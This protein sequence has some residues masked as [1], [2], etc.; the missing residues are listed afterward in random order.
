MENINIGVV[1]Y[2]V[3]NKLKDSYFESNLL[4]ESK[5][6]AY[7]F[8]EVIKN[9]PILQ[10]EF[11]VFNNIEN[12]HISEDAIAVR[13]IDNNIKL[14]EIYTIDE[15]NEEK[16]KLKR[17]VNEDADV[18]DVN[19]Y[20][21]YDAIDVLIE[22]SLIDYNDVNVNLIHEAFTKVINHVKTPKTLDENISNDNELDV[23]SINEDVIEIAVSKFNE[24][25]D[26]LDESDRNLLQTLLKSKVKEKKEILENYKV[27]N[28][29]L[30][31]NMNKDSIKENVS[32]AINK[33]KNMVYNKNTID[34]D[35]IDLYELKKDLNG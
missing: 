14:F 28:L 26:S 4:K 9:S 29:Q 7:D 25:Y 20:D 21:L 8:L 19:N 22:Q 16:N 6:I 3:S 34:N 11:K 31:E 2:L 17:F 12:K 24:K 23:E 35:I 1:N 18:E 5:E 30:L 15:I 10:L 27:E 32:N 13:Y 33:I